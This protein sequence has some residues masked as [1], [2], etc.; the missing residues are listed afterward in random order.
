MAY[1]TLFRLIRAS[2]K[3]G[4]Q[5]PYYSPVANRVRFRIDNDN[6]STMAI[7]IKLVITANE[8]F[9]SKL[10]NIQLENI[11]LHEIMH[12]VYNHHERYMNNSLRNVLPH[13]IHNM[14]MDL[15]INSFIDPKHLPKD[16][17]L[18]KNFGLPK[19]KSYEEYIY[20]INRDMPSTLKELLESS[21]LPNDLEINED[22]YDEFKDI[23]KEILIDL[24]NEMEKAREGNEADSGDI[25]RKIK[26]KKYRWEQ[27]FQN[28]ITTKVTEITAGFR[29]RTYA[30]ANRRYSHIPDII[31]PQFVDYKKKISLI[32]IMDISGSMGDNVNKMYGIMKSMVDIMDIDIKVKIL[33]VNVDVENIIHDFNF[34]KTELE[35]M[36]G[37]GTEMGSGLAYIY[38]NRLESDL[39][40]VMTDSYTPWPD[41]PLFPDKTVVLTDNPDEY[42]GPYPMYPVYF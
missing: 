10:Q 33:E 13:S 20:M 9:V 35:S 1:S 18:A 31:F 37:G 21:Y 8:S 40:I 5:F 28:I 39:I 19:G 32:I 24:I 7:G 38:D 6:I 17:F 23:Y 30:R 4:E 34:N 12:Y 29:Y 15:E 22:E 25:L 36:D 16:V 41:P 11:V 26:K 2:K 27:I 42:D 3:V 14:A